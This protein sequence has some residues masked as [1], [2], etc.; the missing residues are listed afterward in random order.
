MSTGITIENYSEKAFVIR[1]DTRPMKEQLK[2]GGAKWNPSLR[3]GAGWIIS[4]KSDYIDLLLDTVTVLN[5]DEFVN[6]IRPSVSSPTIDRRP[7]LVS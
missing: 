7:I 1:G 2:E 5:E 6:D 4:K 3:G